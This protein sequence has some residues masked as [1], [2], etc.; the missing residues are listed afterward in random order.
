MKSKATFVA[1]RLVIEPLLTAAQSSYLRSWLK[2]TRLSLTEEEVDEAL[3]SEVSEVRGLR[4][5]LGLPPGPKGAFMLGN[6]RFPKRSGAFLPDTPFELSLRGWLYF[7]QGR[8]R[9]PE[10][11]VEQLKP[12]LMMLGAWGR[13]IKTVRVKWLDVSSINPGCIYISGAAVEAVPAVIEYPEPVWWSLRNA[14]ADDVIDF[15]GPQCVEQPLHDETT[16]NDG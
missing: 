13:G 10:Q 7:N 11:Y 3:Q 15:G 6:A 4:D 12:I 5:R 2:A 9:S 1:T 8:R 14:R 16:D